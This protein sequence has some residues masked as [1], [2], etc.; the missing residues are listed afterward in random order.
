MMLTPVRAYVC[1]RISLSL[2][3]SPPSPICR[4]ARK[5]AWSKTH[6]CSSD[7]FCHHCRTSWL[8]GPMNPSSDI[9]TLKKTFVI[10]LLLRQIDCVLV[11]SGERLLSPFDGVVLGD[12]AIARSCCG[13]D[14]PERQPGAPVGLGERE[15]AREGLRVVPLVA[16]E[17]D[18]PF[19]RPDLLPP[20]PIGVVGSVR[21]VH[22]ELPLT[23]RTEVE[24][25]RR[26]REPVRAPPAREVLVGRERLEH[27]PAG[28][29][30]EPLHH[31][32]TVVCR[33]WLFHLSVPFSAIP[34]H[35]TRDGRKPRPRTARSRRS[36]RGLPA[37][38][39]RPGGRSDADPAC[40]RRPI[41]PSSGPSGALTSPAGRGRAPRRWRRPSAP[42]P[43]AP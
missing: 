30:D 36:I 6:P 26:R 3:V 28:R 8:S 9:V 1:S 22:G 12:G 17:G 20:D 5:N 32:L 18:Y 24:R 2:P 42:G 13:K 29:F 43:S 23:A 41:R 19:R 4:L 10:S 39:G 7:H 34:G 25:S 11:E 27:E 16:V 37:D 38:H 40:P 35:T 33:L 21:T 31:D 14:R 15:D